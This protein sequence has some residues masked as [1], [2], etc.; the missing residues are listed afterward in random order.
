MKTMINTII[1]AMVSSVIATQSYAGSGNCGCDS[2]KDKG[3]E[4][5]A[6]FKK[7]TTEELKKIVEAKENVVILDA[8]SGK[9][10]D[11]KR[12]A[13]AKSLNA[14]STKEDIEK[15]VASKDARIITYCAGT[16]CPA[17]EKLA[18]HLR[19]LGYTDITEYPEGIKGWTSAGHSSE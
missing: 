11:G 16:T 6:T 18:K 19:K 1:I 8:R 12:I 4:S 17:S 7:L 3:K 15:V 10:D 2:K 9:W 13:G 14:E 5:N